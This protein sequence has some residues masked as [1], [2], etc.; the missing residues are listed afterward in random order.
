MPTSGADTTKMQHGDPMKAAAD[1]ATPKP[2]AKDQ[3]RALSTQQLHVA[4]LL[5]V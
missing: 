4:L 1:N 5:R 2:A 3:V